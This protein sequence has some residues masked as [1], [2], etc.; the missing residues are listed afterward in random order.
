MTESL[1]IW[2]S[3]G[4]PRGLVFCMI[5]LGMTTF[6]LK[7]FASTQSI[8]EESNAIAEENSDRWAHAFGLDMLGMVAM[9]QGQNEEAVTCFT[10]SIARSKE[11]G[12][13]FNGTQTVI[14]LG[15]AYT[16]LGDREKARCLFVDAYANAY[17]NKWTLIIL[18]ILISYLEMGCDLPGENQLAIAL[19]IL[20]HPSVT[21][22]VR[23]RSESICD[24]LKSSLSEYQI[25]NAE[26][27]AG[28]KDP[29]T[30]AREIIK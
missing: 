30:W 20:S 25:E 26:T 28:E 16:V 6:G 14:H 9:A 24:K 18:N 27:I 5:Y 22:N 1:E 7:D 21:P 4:D 19:S 8:L 2:R 10:Q 29:E 15:Q 12:D 17:Q 23:M 11:I 3:V 13:Q